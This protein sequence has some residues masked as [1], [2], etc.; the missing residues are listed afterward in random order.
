MNDGYACDMTALSAEQRDRHRELSEK[1]R[2]V[3]LAFEELPDG[4]AARIRS[5]AISAAEID[6]FLV[7]EKLCCPF[8]TLTMD[9][10]YN[11]DDEPALYKVSI[12]G[13]GDIKPFIRAEFGIPD[14]S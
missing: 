12:T 7:L 5:A 2:P 6:E 13:P 11:D 3:V 4:Y 10:E 1:L 9:V 14:G 8:F